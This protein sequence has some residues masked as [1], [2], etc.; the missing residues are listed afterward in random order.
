[1]QI[2][3]KNVL[4]LTE[5][6]S[7]LLINSVQKFSVSSLCSL[8]RWLSECILFQLIITK[9]FSDERGRLIHMHGKFEEL[10]IELLV[11]VHSLKKT[12]NESSFFLPLSLFRRTMHRL[13]RR[14]YF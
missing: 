10:L 9:H 11:I 5:T 6:R 3:V 1:M 2:N 14:K 4:I 7:K 8:C 13:D 12:N